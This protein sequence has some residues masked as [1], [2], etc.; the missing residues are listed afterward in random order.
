MF[1]LTGQVLSKIGRNIAIDNVERVYKNEKG[2]VV[3]EKTGKYPEVTPGKYTV[4]ITKIPD[5]YEFKE[6]LQGKTS[7]VEVPAGGQ[8]KH[9]A[10]IETLLGGLDI[11]IT[12]EPSG[13]VVPHAK[14]T[15]TMPDG[16]K[17]ECETDDNGMITQFAK[18]DQFGNYTSPLGE[19]TYVVTWVPDGYTVTLNKENKGTVTA[20]N[21][22]SLESKIATK[23]E[24]KTDKTTTNTKTTTSKKT[25]DTTPIALVVILMGLSLAAATAIVIKRR[26]NRA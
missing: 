22:T 26:K 3:D 17:V 6:K 10:V 11:L 21:L 7:K 24:S 14:V 9:E 25:G 16:T 13:R 23:S 19:Y 15:V 20:G 8:G 1:K 5:N 12:E 4:T 2:E 18:K